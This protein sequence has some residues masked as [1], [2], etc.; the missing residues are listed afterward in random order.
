M[1]TPVRIEY[2]TRLAGEAARVPPSYV[3]P[4]AASMTVI[5]PELVICCRR[6]TIHIPTQREPVIAV[7]ES[8][9]VPVGNSRLAGPVKVVVTIRPMIAPAVRVVPVPF[10]VMT[11]WSKLAPDVWR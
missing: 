9:E 1:L 3:C 10:A 2:I 6:Q 8:I 5:T 11:M 7:L 4:D